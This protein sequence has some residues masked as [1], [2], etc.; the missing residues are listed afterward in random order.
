MSDL[1]MGRRVKRHPRMLSNQNRLSMKG[2]SLLRSMK[3]RSSSWGTK[4]TL[5]AVEVRVSCKTW[6][7]NIIRRHAREKSIE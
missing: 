2:S 5:M 7:L 4:S 1:S 6:K 3:S